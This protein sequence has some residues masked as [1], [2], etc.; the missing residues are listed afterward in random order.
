[1]VG[2]GGGEH[3]RTQGAIIVLRSEAIL[4]AGRRA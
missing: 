4:S 3:A 2:V 1:M